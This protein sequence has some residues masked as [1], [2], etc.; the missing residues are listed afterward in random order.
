MTRFLLVKVYLA[1]EPNL[2][3]DSYGKHAKS[4]CWKVAATLCR[5]PMA[6]VS[7][8]TFQ[9]KKEARAFG[10][11]P[12]SACMEVHVLGLFANLLTTSSNKAA[13]PHEL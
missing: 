11:L 6:D 2:A 12:Y 7:N 8:S 4:A 10:H 5:P 1:Q 3:T 9:S 13:S